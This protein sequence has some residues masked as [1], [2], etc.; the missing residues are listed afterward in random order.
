[1]HLYVG[2]QNLLS[3][4]GIMGQEG[5]EIDL[6]LS[7]SEMCSPHRHCLF[8][9]AGFLFFL[10]AYLWGVVVVTVVLRQSLTM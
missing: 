4:E 9:I 8:K 6:F 5:G 7:L 2:A 3:L 10:F 1:M